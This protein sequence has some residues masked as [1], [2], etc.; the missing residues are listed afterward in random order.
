MKTA[1]SLLLDMP[2]INQSGYALLPLS[3]P[4]Q[5]RAIRDA[6][7]YLLT[8]HKDDIATEELAAKFGMS[9][10]N[11]MRRFKA[12]TGR[13]PGAYLQ[14]VRMDAAK[15]LLERGRLSVK[16]IAAEIGYDDISFFRSLFKRST[17]MNPA[18]YRARFG[19]MS[20]RGGDGP[21]LS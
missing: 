19:A 8:H 17:G 18:E 2:R 11:F 20:A 15:H 13:M 21:E 5:D 4:H 6:E 9:G 12:A 7:A 3:P 1:K 14:A 10:R 16:Q